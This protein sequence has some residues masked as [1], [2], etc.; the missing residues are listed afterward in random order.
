MMEK[1]PQNGTAVIPLEVETGAILPEVDGQDATA[2][3]VEMAVILPEV[4]EMI[5][6]GTHQVL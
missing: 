4:A 2:P 5:R 1:I 6:P 3:E